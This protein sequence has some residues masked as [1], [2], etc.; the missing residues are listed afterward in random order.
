MIIKKTASAQLAE[1]CSFFANWP[2]VN[3]NLRNENYIIEICVVLKKKCLVQKFISPPPRFSMR[4]SRWQLLT[5]EG[6]RQQYFP[7]YTFT[8]DGLHNR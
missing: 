8:S 5:G 6:T 2:N 7:S 1:H 3:V 4:L